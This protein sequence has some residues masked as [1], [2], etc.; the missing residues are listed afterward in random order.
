MNHSKRQEVVG[1]VKDLTKKDLFI[2]LLSALK[3]ESYLYASIL[4]KEIHKRP[5]TPEEVSAI[6]QSSFYPQL[7]GILND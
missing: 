5:F 3:T 6:R 4:K 1:L 7:N 2:H